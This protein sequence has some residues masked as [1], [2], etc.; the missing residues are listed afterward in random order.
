MLLHLNPHQDTAQW[1]RAGQ[2]L[3]VESG[4]VLLRETPGPHS[5]QA[6][7]RRLCTGQAHRVV[8]GGWVQI[9]ARVSSR[10]RLG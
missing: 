6:F 5:F 4:E 7:T 2:A 1:L 9:N 3:F 10:L 8:Q